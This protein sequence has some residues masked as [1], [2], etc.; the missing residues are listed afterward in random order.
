MSRLPQLVA[1]PQ[2]LI[3]NIN[4]FLN[5]VAVLIHNCQ[6]YS[7]YHVFWRKH[8]YQVKHVSHGHIDI[9]RS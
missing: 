2:L 9:E 8:A 4:I 6:I 7:N 5:V 3:T 1:I